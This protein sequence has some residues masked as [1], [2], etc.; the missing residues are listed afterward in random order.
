M[1]RTILVREEPPSAKILSVGMPASVVNT[2]WS[3]IFKTFLFIVLVDYRIRTL[4]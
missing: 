2:S 1:P 3:L 4:S